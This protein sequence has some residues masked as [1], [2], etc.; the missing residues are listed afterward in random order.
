M[1]PFL[2]H[3]A[4]QAITGHP[5]RIAFNLGVKWNKHP[6]ING[7]SNGNCD[8]NDNDDRKSNADSS[9]EDEE[10]LSWVERSIAWALQQS[11]GFMES[12]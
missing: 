2:I 6:I 9:L 10:R 8:G 1:H 7:Y 11:T 12:V 3:G 5:L 4:G